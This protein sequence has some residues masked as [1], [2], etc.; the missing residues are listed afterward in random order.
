VKNRPG[1]RERI[2]RVQTKPFQMKP[3]RLVFGAWVACVAGVSGQSAPPPPVFVVRLDP[4]AGGARNADRQ[5]VRSAPQEASARERQLQPLPVT[6]LD[7]SAANAVL[8]AQRT[9]ALRFST[10]VPVRQVLMMLVRDTGLSLATSGD[11]DGTFAGELTGVTL[12]QALDLVVKPQGLDYRLEGNA[13]RV[14][15]RETV[16]RILDVNAIAARRDGAGSGDT[17]GDLSESLLSLLSPAGRLGVDRK[18]GLVHVTD[19]PERVDRVSAY[20]ESLEQRLNRQVDIQ[21][22]VIEVLL[23]DAAAPAVNWSSAIGQARTNVAGADALDLERLLK[24]LRKQGTVTVLT[25][26]DVRALHNEQAT[27]RVGVQTPAFEG[28]A[29]AVTPQ[30][31]ADGTILLTVA[32]S[33]AYR[34]ADGAGSASAAATSEVSTAVRIRDGETLVLPG[35]RRGRSEI[36]V[37]LTTKVI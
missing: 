16:T 1:A 12:R 11:A 18:A 23:P 19:Y 7:D 24:A 32:P 29:L 28:F 2:G 34:I 31:A 9:L 10:P 33:V 30:V 25:A 37:L 6:R 26:S 3:L 22:R 17:F 5:V 14:F 15:R 27:I 21:A 36:A 8:D 35:I 4:A 20:I 13:I